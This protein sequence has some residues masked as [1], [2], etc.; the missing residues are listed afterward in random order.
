[1]TDTRPFTKN[2]FKQL[3]SPRSAITDSQLHLKYIRNSIG[4]QNME[5]I[6]NRPC[7]VFVPEAYYE[8]RVL[9]VCFVLKCLRIILA[10]F[11]LR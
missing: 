3:L 7:A 6:F 9:R 11:I 10:H 1:M 5:V 4:Y 8:I 2:Q